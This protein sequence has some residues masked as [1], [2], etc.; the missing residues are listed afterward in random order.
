LHGLYKNLD[1][2]HVAITEKL[3]HDYDMFDARNISQTK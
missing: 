3:G 1:I 2:N